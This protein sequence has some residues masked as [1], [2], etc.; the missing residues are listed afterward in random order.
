ML[1][2][3]SMFEIEMSLLGVSKSSDII[4]YDTAGLGAARVY[5]MFKIFGHEKISVLD[6]GLS[7]WIDSGKPVVSTIETFLVNS[8]SI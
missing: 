8:I 3:A 1:P 2:T 7:A 4:V 6:G 5:W